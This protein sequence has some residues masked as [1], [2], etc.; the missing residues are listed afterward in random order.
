MGKL[1]NWGR[2]DAYTASLNQLPETTLA[3]EP[4][5][6]LEGMETRPFA[7]VRYRSLQGAGAI[8]CLPAR[9]TDP[10]RVKPPSEFVNAGHRK[11]DDYNRGILRDD[12]PVIG[13]DK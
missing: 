1:V 13:V 5:D 6:T 9:S 7:N 11:E 8:P 2:Y 12:I 3:P 10:L 4:N